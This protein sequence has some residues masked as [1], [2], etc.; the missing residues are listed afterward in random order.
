MK[1]CRRNPT[2]KRIVSTL[3]IILLFIL[4]LVFPQ[5][6]FQGASTGL[7]LWF[8]TVL[9]TLLPFFILSNLLIQS[10]SID[11]I[12]MAISPVLC[13]FF[14][15]SP[16]G[17]FAVLTGFLCGC[18]MGS[19]VTADLL[20]KG[21]I[22]RQEGCYLLSFCNNTSPMFIL[23]FL[24]MQNL[25]DDRLKLPTLAILFLS[26]VIISFGCRPFAK[27]STGTYR[28][29]SSQPSYASLSAFSVCQ[30]K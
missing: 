30:P 11:W 2:M 19:K 18:P 21:C 10:G 4:M 28:N 5:A 1:G 9:P 17:A 7:V 20:R 27:K 24:V 23:S 8:Q 12:A 6:A 16:Y 13:R 14:R 3:C 15:V 26:P 29:I 25:K 22:T